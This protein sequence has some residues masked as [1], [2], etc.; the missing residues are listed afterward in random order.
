V[1]VAFCS[2][3]DF[4]RVE[5][6]RRRLSRL[7]KRGYEQTLTTNVF[8]TEMGYL[9]LIKKKTPFKYSN[10]VQSPD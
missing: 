5:R 1:G 9:S 7:E 3:E 2:E 4:E 10:A 8:I 6:A